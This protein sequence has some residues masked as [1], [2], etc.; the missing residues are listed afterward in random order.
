MASENTVHNPI[1]IDAETCVKCDLCDWMCP[2]DV[3]YKKPDDRE[4]LPEVRYP[5]EC[6]YCGLCQSVCPTRA[7]TIV[8]PECMIDNRTDVITLLGKPES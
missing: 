2:G 5:D 1:Q 3:I 6:W 7:I 4:T 8:F